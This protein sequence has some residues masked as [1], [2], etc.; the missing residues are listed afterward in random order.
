MRRRDTA[1]PVGAARRRERRRNVRDAFV[2]RRRSCVVGRV[3][4]L[5]DDVVTTGATAQACARALAAA[6]ASE[7]RLLTAARA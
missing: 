4:T 5:V 1:A 6:G 7:V 3:V 2:V